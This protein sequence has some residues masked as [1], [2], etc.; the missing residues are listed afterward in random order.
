[1]STMEKVTVLHPRGQPSG[2]F[3]K[4]L[5]PSVSDAILDPTRQP[6]KDIS[7][8]EK[9]Q[10][11]P[12]LDSLEGKTVYLVE[13][14]FAGA[15]E[16]IDEVKGWFERK[17]PS[18]TTVSRSKQGNMWTDDPELWQEIQE[19]GDAVIIGVGG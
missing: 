1:M 12:R 19:N 14:G 13:T 15:A 6:T 11:A 8:M 5:D 17:M 3:G 4:V 16:F 7:A 10:M 18:V 9:Q 2:V